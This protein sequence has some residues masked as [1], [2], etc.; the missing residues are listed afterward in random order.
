MEHTLDI[1]IA[2][3]CLSYLREIVDRVLYLSEGRIEK[4]YTG[5][6]F[7]R[8]SDSERIGMGAASFIGQRMCLDE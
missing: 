6:E 8:L 7:F 2:E 5:A 4:E 1:I 3:H